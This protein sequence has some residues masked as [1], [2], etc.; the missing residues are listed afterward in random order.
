MKRRALFDVYAPMNVAPGSQVLNPAPGWTTHPEH[1][2]AV[3]P[4]NAHVQIRYRGEVIAASVEALKLEESGHAPVY[5][6]PRKDVRMDRLVRSTHETYCPFKG[7]ASYY[8]L[9]SGPQDVA[10]SYEHPYDEMDSIRELL[11]F[12]PDKVEVRAL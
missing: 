12:Y 10:W 6:V 9:K 1:R 4:A 11:A 3:V 5:Y 8:S 2:I 7:S